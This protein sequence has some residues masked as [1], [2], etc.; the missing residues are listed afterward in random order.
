MLAPLE[1]ACFHVANG[2][3]GRSL[4][5]VRGFDSRLPA[6]R[7]VGRVGRSSYR[8][9]FSPKSPGFHQHEF[10]ASTSACAVGADGMPAPAIA[11]D[12]IDGQAVS[13]STEPAGPTVSLGVLGHRQR[14]EREGDYYERGKRL[15]A[16]ILPLRVKFSQIHPRGSICGSLTGQY[17][18]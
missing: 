16:Q 9:E 1:L 4:S 14:V 6:L 12:G 15:A 17:Q 7:A 8:A 3:L 10:I 13:A 18:A 5:P 11:A 2:S